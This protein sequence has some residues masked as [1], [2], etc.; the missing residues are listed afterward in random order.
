MQ[1]QL[2]PLD[3]RVVH[4]L[5]LFHRGDGPGAHHVLVVIF[6]V[7]HITAGQNAHT[8]FQGIQQLALLNVLNDFQGN[9]AGVVRD[10]DGIDFPA[11]VPGLLALNGED[12]SPNAGAANIRGDLF[13]R[14][15]RGPAHAAQNILSGVRQ[16]GGIQ[17]L[18]CAHTHRPGRALLLFGRSAG[19]TFLH[20]GLILGHLFHNR[21]PALG[22]LFPFH[23]LY[24]DRLSQFQ[25]KPPLKIHRN[26]DVKFFGDQVGKGFVQAPGYQQVVAAV[27]QGDPE[28]VLPNLGGGIFKTAVDIGVPALQLHGQAGEILR[29]EGLLRI[30][31][32]NHSPAKLQGGILQ[33]PLRPKKGR[34][35]HWLG[36][37]HHHLQPASFPFHSDRAHFSLPHFFGQGSAVNMVCK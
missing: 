21:F 16:D 37:S 14:N 26:G 9:R 20:H 22:F 13:N 23:R 19:R 15:R 1:M 24:L 36:E 30:P 28:G 18:R 8:L 27:T 25:R 31:G 3:F 11:L 12:F 6:V 2:H 17:V 5:Q 10:I 32:V 35:F 34:P 33:E 4:Y 7:F 29:G